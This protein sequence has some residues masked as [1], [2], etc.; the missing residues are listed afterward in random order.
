MLEIINILTSQVESLSLRRLCQLPLRIGFNLPANINRGKFIRTKKHFTIKPIILK[1]HILVLQRER[2]TRA[3]SLLKQLFLLK[4]WWRCNFQGKSNWVAFFAVRFEGKNI[5]LRIK[6][7]LWR[8]K[9]IMRG[10]ALFSCDISKKRV[11]MSS[12]G[13]VWWKWQ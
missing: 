13:K 8:E 9:N 1:L 4:S 5:L 2:E 12:R 11:T 3:A 6:F 10:R 7:K